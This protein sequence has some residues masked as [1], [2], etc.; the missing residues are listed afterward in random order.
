MEG[1]DVDSDENDANEI[2]SHQIVVDSD[3]SDDENALAT[4]C[5]FLEEGQSY[6]FWYPREVRLTEWRFGEKEPEWGLVELVGTYVR[7]EPQ[8]SYQGE[9]HLYPHYNS[10]FEDVK[11]IQR[12]E[13]NNVVGYEKWHGMNHRRSENTVVVIE[14]VKPNKRVYYN[15]S[16]APELLDQRI[17]QL[18]LQ[19][20]K[21]TY[22]PAT[23]YD[24][25][26][27]QH[28]ENIEAARE[29]RP[30]QILFPKASNSTVVST[31]SHQT[32]QSICQLP[33]IPPVNLANPRELGVEPVPFELFPRIQRIIR[34]IQ[35]NCIIAGSRHKTTKKRKTNKKHKT[36]KKRKTNKKL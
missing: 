6:F 29:R 19:G 14:Y 22:I 31:V 24:E 9:Y 13:Y 3:I 28:K 2:E 20:N 15:I 25:W 12:D 32:I 36:N 1:M 4:T 16:E 21:P 5:E 8:Y 27:A 26:L 35:T 33:N 18:I 30:P 17:L 10:V 23:D 34:R 7:R 11:V